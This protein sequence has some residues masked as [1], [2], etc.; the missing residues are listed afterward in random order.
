MYQHHH[1]HHHHHHREHFQ[2]ILLKYIVDISTLMLNKGNIYPLAHI[3]IEYTIYNVQ[4]TIYIIY[5]Y[6]YIYI[7]ISI[8]NI[9]VS[10]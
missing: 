2:M 6:I 1:N 4:C 3:G 10:T 9:Y 5:I 7:Y 8:I